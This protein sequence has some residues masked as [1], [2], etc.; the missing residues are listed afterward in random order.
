MKLNNLFENPSPYEKLVG[1]LAGKYSRRINIYTASFGVWSFWKRTY[2]PYS[3]NVDSLWISLAPGSRLRY[4]YRPKAS[5]PQRCLNH[6]GLH[7]RPQPW[8]FCCSKS[9]DRMWFLSQFGEDDLIYLLFIFPVDTYSRKMWQLESQ[10]R[11]QISGFM[12]L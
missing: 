7:P 12:I 6:Y 5:R 4:L 2:R 11:L 8:R 3:K 10:F 1:D 9:Y